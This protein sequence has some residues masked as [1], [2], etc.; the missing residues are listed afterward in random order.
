M[1]KIIFITVLSVILMNIITSNNNYLYAKAYYVEADGSYII[2][3]VPEENVDIAKKRAKLEAL[4]NAVEKAGVYVESYTHTI[5][6]Q[7]KRDEI[8]T[9]AGAILKIESSEIKTEVKGKYIE[10]SCHI[11][12]L[13]DISDL[14]L[15]TVLQNKELLEKTTKQERK[16]YELN[17]EVNKLKSMYKKSSGESER[18]EIQKKINYNER[19]LEAILVQLSDYTSK[20]FLDAMKTYAYKNN[21]E[22]KMGN[23]VHTQNSGAVYDSDM[24]MIGDNAQNGCILIIYT[25]KNGKVFKITLTSLLNNIEARVKSYETEEVILG[26]AGIDEKRKRNFMD[27]IRARDLPFGVAIWSY[28]ANRNIGVEHSRYPNNN[29]LFY[30]RITAYDRLFELERR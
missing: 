15:K 11:K 25:N 28:L 21:V 9:L 13:I 7:V 3:D 4:R 19:N 20:E 14:D 16:I 26:V 8:K 24:V 1:K 22:L 23:V 17:E 5:N 2:G 29:N 10:F 30:V 18:K 27:D 6:S 12:A